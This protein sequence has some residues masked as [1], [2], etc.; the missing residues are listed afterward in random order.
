MKSVDYVVFEL[1]HRGAIGVQLRSTVRWTGQR[2][3]D[4]P[5]G[6]AKTLLRS[7]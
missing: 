2:T 3:E 5:F 7:L 6:I 1:P 4:L